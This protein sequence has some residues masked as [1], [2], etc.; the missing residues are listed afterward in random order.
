M[1]DLVLL[2]QRAAVR[3]LK[4]CC[5]RSIAY[6]FAH[7]DPGVPSYVVLLNGSTESIAAHNLLESV[8]LR[9]E[10][11]IDRM[12]IKLECIN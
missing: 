8:I 7:L 3:E 11:N 4:R 1:W 12:M 2:V 9:Q 5:K 10:L 6:C